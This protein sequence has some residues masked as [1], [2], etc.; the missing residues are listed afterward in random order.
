MNSRLTKTPLFGTMIAAAVLVSPVPSLAQDSI[1]TGDGLLSIRALMPKEIR[2]GEQFTFDVE[3]TNASDNTVLHD[4]ELKQR[5][6]Q[7][8]NVE[9]VAMKGKA[10]TPDRSSKAATEENSNDRSAMKIAT[11]KPGESCMLIVTASADEEGEL[12]SCLEIASYTPALCL[13]SQVVAPELVL[14]KIAPKKANRCDVIELEYTIKNGGSGNVGPFQ[15]TD[16]LGDGLATIDGDSELSFPVDGLTA[17][18]SRKFVARVYATKPGSFSS[19]A[20][21]FVFP[22]CS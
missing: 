10:A 22:R 18:D 14:T 6:T 2:V 5:K 12:R 7:G 17:G 9:A 8:F 15:V 16:S 20:M 4:I 1:T 19:R 3:V 13:T 21:W 11:L